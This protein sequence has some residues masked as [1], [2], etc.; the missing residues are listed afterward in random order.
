MNSP[1]PVKQ[2]ITPY[3]IETALTLSRTQLNPRSIAACLC[4]EDKARTPYVRPQSCLGG[5]P[6]GVSGVDF[7]I[8]ASN[9]DALSAAEAISSSRC[10]PSGT[11]KAGLDFIPWDPL[12]DQAQ[13]QAGSSTS[14]LDPGTLANHNRTVSRRRQRF[15]VAQP[16]A[17]GVDLLAGS[18]LLSN[19]DIS[20]SSSSSACDRGHGL[21]ATEELTVGMVEHLVGT[22]GVGELADEIPA[23][24]A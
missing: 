8:T 24:R 3:G 14:F 13:A 15:S 11:S 17:C 2:V 19:D 22:R 18:K 20:P 9:H 5:A 6:L 4:I 23:C 16:P 1:T 21:P 10:T 12:Q 7:T